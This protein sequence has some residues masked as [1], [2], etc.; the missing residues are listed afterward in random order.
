MTATISNAVGNIR[1]APYKIIHLQH[2][3]I[4]KGINK[5]STLTFSAIISDEKKGQLCKSNRC[6]NFY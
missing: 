1:I 6:G 5:H 4:T 3:K 2:M